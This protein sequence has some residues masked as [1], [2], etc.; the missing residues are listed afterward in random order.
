[1]TRSAIKFVSNNF[2]SINCQGV[3]TSLK[4]TDMLKSLR[5]KKYAEYMLHDMHF[6]NKE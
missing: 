2:V 5:R 4:R 3:S 1:M 6:T